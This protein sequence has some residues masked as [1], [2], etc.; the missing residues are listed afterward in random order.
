VKKQA[1]VK[2]PIRIRYKAISAGNQ[3]IY[4][5]YYYNGKREYEFLKLYLVPE[6]SPENKEANKATLKLANAIKAQRIVELQN[7]QH[8]FSSG[9]GKSKVH[10]IEYIKTIAKK[11][12][13]LA[14]GEERGSCQF[15]LSLAYHLKQYSGDRT[16]F[17][18]IDKKYCMGFIEYIKTAKSMLNG[19][20]LNENTQR[21][22]IKR[23]AS[24][25]NSAIADEMIPSNPFMQIK[26]EDIPK[27]HSAEVCYLTLDEVRS[28]IETPCYYS[29]IK[30]GFLFSCF[31]G[32]RFSDV[33]ALTWSKLQRDSEGNTLINF[34]QKKTQ[35]WENLPVSREAIKF[36]PERGLA[37]GDDLVF[38]FQ[39][40]GYINSI[41]KTWAKSAG[42]NK[43]VTFHVARHTNATL[44]LSLEVPIETV[45]KILGHSDI[46]T[47]LIY[48]KVIDKSKR[49]AVNKLDGLTGQ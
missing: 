2:E 13:E 47:T 17:K 12:R 20:P 41:I 9:G 28:L 22:Y 32:L 37:S 43:K 42:I 31:T 7:N 23:L 33:E 14:G 11:K 15:Y 21:Q 36:L 29:N 6:N 40:G 34:T 10:L 35:K 5:D 4:L 46:K 39:S 49:D 25:I 16:S 26:P 48:A 1:K 8:G 24:V 18:H 30:N 3:S 19:N 27:G 44:L 45:S 38:K